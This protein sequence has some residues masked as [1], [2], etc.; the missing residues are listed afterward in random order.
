MEIAEERCG[1]DPFSNSFNCAKVARISANQYNE[2]NHSIH[3]GLY[4]HARDSIDSYIY[5]VGV[6]RA[7]PFD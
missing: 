6:F 2:G 1:C 3:L 4:W 5:G 7:F